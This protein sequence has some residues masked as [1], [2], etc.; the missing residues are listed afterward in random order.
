MNFREFLEEWIA[1]YKKL[2]ADNIE[3]LVTTRTAFEMCLEEFDR[4]FEQRSIGD[5][6]MTLWWIEK[7]VPDDE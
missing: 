3:P 4:Q 1:V 2:E 6:E 5:D 7:V